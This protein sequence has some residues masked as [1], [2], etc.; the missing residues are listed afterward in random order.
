MTV[1]ATTT[2][3]LTDILA[4]ARARGIRLWS[5]NGQ[6]RFKAPKGALTPEERER[7][8]ASRDQITAALHGRA[9]LSYSQ[10]AHWH[11]HRL[12]ARPAI[13]QIAT[14]TRLH[15]RL[16]VELLREAIARVTLHHDALRTRVLIHD[17]V[18][19][20]EVSPTALSKLE[21]SDI[22]SVPAAQR[23]PEIQRQIEQLILQPITLSTGPLF[24]ATL[25]HVNERE[26]I[27]I[28]A[29]EH[30]ISDAVSKTI[31]LRDIFTAYTQLVTGHGVSLPQIGIQFPDF[32][33]WQ[34]SRESFFLKK[35]GPYWTH[36]LAGCGRAKFP[37]DPHFRSGELRKGWGVAPI[38]LG[39]TLKSNLSEWSRARG[40]TLVMTAFVAYAALVSRWCDLSDFVLPYQ[41]DGRLHPKTENTLGFLASPLYL[42]IRTLAEDTPQDLLD[43]IV[44]EYCNAHE[45]HD[46]SFLEAQQ[47][48][49]DFTLNSAFNWISHG[50]PLVLTELAQTQDALKLETI[51]FTHPLFRTLE[52]DFEPALALQD[53]PGAIV[54]GVYFPLNRF[55]PETLERFARSFRML[56]EQIVSDPNIRLR[57]FLPLDSP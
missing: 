3:P 4:F 43:R 52:T 14:A 8:K 16:N 11:L 31:L 30:I 17:G 42:R 48:R 45:H 32:A 27:L 5:E 57:D 19:L 12:H 38:R 22:T 54:G 26:H 46:A 50:H 37:P 20:Q 15:G 33:A 24:G 18:P 23:E 36:H 13:R 51:D 25:I 6:L 56:L 41:T 47:P 28:T 2:Q 34:R 55:S 53:V 39:A 9:P 35:H 44:E 29:M 49:P 7:L 21:I 40:T 10:L 1:T